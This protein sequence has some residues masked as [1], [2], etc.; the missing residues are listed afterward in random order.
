MKIVAELL[1]EINDKL[2]NL[3]N[4]TISN[5]LKKFFKHDVNIRG[6]KV[7]NVYKLAK[8]YSKQIDKMEKS[9]V[10]AVCESLMSSDF[11]EDFLIAYKFMMQIKNKLTMDDFV[12]L[13]NLTQKYVNSWVKTDTFCNHVIGGLIDMYPQILPQIKLWAKSENLWLRRAS[14]VSFIL[15]GR[16]GKF[17]SD[18]F[19]IADILLT[20]SED[21]VQKGYGWALKVVGQIQPQTVYDFVNARHSKMPRTAFRYAIEK[22]P[23]DMRKKAMTF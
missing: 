9:E 16:H 7:P 4:N 5:D 18:V 14:A 17:H 22:F 1:S 20:D 10:F 6:I 13:Q 19:E 15:L 11:Q 2:S 8:D 23:A 12:F 21:M 3:S